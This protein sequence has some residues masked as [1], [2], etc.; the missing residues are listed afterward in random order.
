MS[1]FAALLLLSLSVVGAAVALSGS[2]ATAD[3]SSAAANGIAEPAWISKNTFSFDVL[4]TQNDEGGFNADEV[5][6]Q[7]QAAKA[8]HHDEIS[9]PQAEA[10]REDS[11]DA[12]TDLGTEEAIELVIDVF[13]EQLDALTTLPTDPLTTSESTP[14]FNAG[15]DSSVRIDPPGAE[16]SELVVSDS[17]LRNEDGQILSGELQVGVDGFEPKAPLAVVELPSKADGS[18]D[19]SD[20]DIAFEFADATSVS[21]QL[22][23]PTD[24]SGEEMVFY[25][26]TQTDT[27]TAITYTLNGIETFN[28]LRSEESPESFTLTYDLPEGATLSATNDGG[29]VVRD[30]ESK[31]LLTVFPPFAVD[32]Q[33]TTVPMTLT[34]DGESVVLS[35]PH[36]GK[37][38]AYPILVDPV[39][40]VRDWW[41]N[42]SADG[43]GGWGDNQSGTFNYNASLACPASL[44]SIDPCGG[45]GAGVYTS[46]VPGS[47]YPADSKGFWRWEVPGG[48]T[49]RIQD[50]TIS[51]WRFRKGN[52]NAGSAFYNVNNP[53]TGVSN[54]YTTTTGGGG[55]GLTLSGGNG[56]KYIHSGLSTPTANTIP[57]GATNWRYN[58]LAGYTATLTDGE[59]PTVNLSGEPTSWLGANQTVNINAASRDLGLGLGWIQYKLNSGAWSNKWVGWCTGTYPYLCPNETINQS[60]TFNTNDLP[61][62][63]S[64]AT[65]KAIDIV[66]G[67]GHETQKSAS[68]FVDKNSP[69]IDSISPLVANTNT[70]ITGPLDLV[71]GVSDA[72]SG[73]RLVEFL[74]DDDV[75][76]S[77]ETVCVG[78]EVCSVEPNMQIDLSGFTA[79]SHSWKIRVT[80]MAGNSSVKEGTMSLTSG[81]P[82]PDPSFETEEDEYSM[83]TMN[84][85]GVI[86]TYAYSATDPDPI[87]DTPSGTVQY[88]NSGAKYG[89]IFCN[90]KGPAPGVIGR[91]ATVYSTAQCYGNSSTSGFQGHKVKT[92][93]EH[94]NVRQFLPDTWPDDEC[95]T[96]SYPPSSVLVPRSNSVMIDCTGK[97]YRGSF[98]NTLRIAGTFDARSVF[99]TRQT[100][101]N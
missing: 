52:S 68:V 35:V 31:I 84:N 40:H 4:A 18:V 28:Y 69:S 94:K 79:G 45:T 23:S 78:T 93:I 48:A 56:F 37:D 61:N 19:L 70:S 58:R 72:T 22:V 10:E 64:V 17:P 8:D 24:G 71:L 9:T 20:V 90:V 34:V 57:T 29:A 83:I 53:S 89:A 95:K 38:F 25:P 76:N 11:T 101:C 82:L 36:K 13:E 92:C 42:G 66:S 59:A 98:V 50:V 41:T 47:F 73:V 91:Y 26:N 85:A 1:R 96:L 44:S 46:A 33:G 87:P 74:L 100:F 7:I 43:F 86:D 39:Q 2:A 32:A 65:F 51:S 88:R 21:G 99:K 30:S 81:E 55:S 75:I 5:A 62:G 12:F 97:T 63:E 6:A 49:S 14:K 60:A 80:D 3:E 16:D 54:G 67:S 77:N 15:S 27:D